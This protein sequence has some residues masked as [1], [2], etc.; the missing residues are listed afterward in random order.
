MRSCGQLF[1]EPPEGSSPEPAT[2]GLIDLEI[3]QSI[4]KVPAAAWDA[5]AGDDDPFLE[6]AFLAALEDSGSVGERA[7][8]E[9]RFVL[10]RQAGR[11]VGAVPLYLKSNSYGEFIFD[12]SWANAAHRSGIRYYPKLVAAVPFTPATGRRL[13]IAPGADEATVAAALLRGVRQT[14]EDE[15][16]SSIHFLFCTE[17]EKDRLERADFMPRLSMQFHWHNRHQAEDRP[18]SSFDDYLGTFR[19]RNRKQV[20]KERQAAGAHGLGF[21]T[22]TGGELGARDWRAL[23]RFY[24]AN[25]ARHG[26]IAYLQPAFF[27]VMRET[28]AHRLVATLAYR[29]DEPVA[30]TVNFEKGRHL[31][32]RY[33]G[34]LADYQMLH[35]EL[36]YYRLIERAIERG[37]TRF[38]AGAQGEHKLKRGLVPSY[39]HSA[40]WIR[41]KEL[42]QAIAAYVRTEADAVA[43]EVRLYAEHSP[44]RSE[45]GKDDAPADD[46]EAT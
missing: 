45:T 17:P 16:A 14:A 26:G 4:T 39:T 8:C 12:W 24:V 32:G 28:L 34:C 40:H 20:R 1:H 43:E 18:F 42:G 6:H 46:A 13:L 10:A 22:A 7:G 2:L 21:R 41:H 44:F 33:W 19:S 27:E 38:E 36:C 5:M 23:H 35:F 25:V 31:Y 3:I 29:G 9:P 11:L 37:Y 15:R 30:G